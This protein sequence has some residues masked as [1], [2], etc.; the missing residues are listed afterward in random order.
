M[1][2]PRALV[3]D[4]AQSFSDSYDHHGGGWRGGFVATNQMLNP[5]YPVFDSAERTINAVRAGDW[6]AAGYAYGNYGVSALQATALVV[7]GTP[8]AP[9]TLSS[10]S[11]GPPTTSTVANLADSAVVVRGGTRPLPEPGH[12]FS[13]AYGS[14]LEAAAAGVPYGQIRSTTAGAI[15]ATGG[16]VEVAPELTR[17]GLLNESHVNICLGSGPCPFGPLQPNPVPKAGRIQ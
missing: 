14:T 11:F 6:R 13:G 2:N 3:G 4:M 16:S 10:T 12:V 17:S 9:T 5:F 8:R 15:R 7:A 1:F